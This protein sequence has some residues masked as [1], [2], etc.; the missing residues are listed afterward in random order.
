MVD[1]G[2]RSRRLHDL[3]HMIPDPERARARPGEISGSWVQAYRDLCE[4]AVLYELICHRSFPTDTLVVRDG[5]L[6]S[7]V[8]R[9]E[10]FIRIRERIEEA[11]QRAYQEDGRRVFL[12]GIA[13]KSK[14][15]D[16]YNLAF[17]LGNV[18]PDG[19]ARYVEIP[20]EMERKRYGWEW[21]RRGPDEA[22]ENEAPWIRTMAK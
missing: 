11:I 10:Y 13:K 7:K 21:N 12:V 8:F 15:L 1:L 16:R 3:S 19:E 4:W 18:P 9:G 2:V 14:V 6:R 22:V 20:R 17:P 5:Q